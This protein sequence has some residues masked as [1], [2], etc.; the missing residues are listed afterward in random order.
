MN[1]IFDKVEKEIV[2][3]LYLK[4]NKKIYNKGEYI[5]FDGDECI[6]LDYIVDGEVEI[7]HLNEEGHK[8]IMNIYKKNDL[9]GLN[10][11]YSSKQYYIMNF[12]AHTDVTILSFQKDDVTNAIK[13]SNQLLMNVLKHLSNT[14]L[15]I[16]SKL[17]S[18]FKVTIREQLINLIYSQYAKQKTNPI[19]LPYTKTKIAN[20]FGVSRTS[21]SRE[22]QR[23][24]IDD[25]IELDRNKIK[26]KKI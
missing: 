19:I 25:L 16:G 2:E 20:I 1:K 12:L 3:E 26:I 23:M 8:K 21:I 24:V 17:K 9:L 4:A 11:I 15:F 5:H 22:L 6:S 7:E 14:S 10:I 18:N 13:K